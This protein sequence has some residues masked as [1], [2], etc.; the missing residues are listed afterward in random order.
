MSDGAAGVVCGVGGAATG[1]RGVLGALDAF[2]VVSAGPGGRGDGD[3]QRVARWAEV[4]VEIDRSDRDA[5]R[6]GAD[7]QRVRAPVGLPDD[8]TVA[9]DPVAAD[10]HAP[11]MGP[12]P[13]DAH[14]AGGLSQSSQSPHPAGTAQRLMPARGVVRVRGM[15]GRTGSQET[16]QADT[17]QQRNN[18]APHGGTGHRAPVHVMP[19]LPACG[20]TLQRPYTAPRLTDGRH[21]LGPGAGAGACGC[22]LWAGC[23]LR[24]RRWTSPHASR[25]SA[26]GARSTDGPS[27]STGAIDSGSSS[28]ATMRP[29]TSLARHPTSPAGGVA[30]AGDPVAAAGACEVLGG[31]IVEVI[32]SAPIA[33]AQPGCRRAGAP[34]GGAAGGDRVVGLPQHDRQVEEDEQDPVDPDQAYSS[35]KST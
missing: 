11:A 8:Q 31:C 21:T 35:W 13:V 17:E 23:R 1:A 4:A 28:I 18:E 29:S 27:S 32:S 30:P 12:A 20:D 22:E 34:G 19:V 5:V 10:R 24:S 25:E 7:P 33:A 3:G 9:L 2:D 6:A 16:E 15:A 26:T 14:A